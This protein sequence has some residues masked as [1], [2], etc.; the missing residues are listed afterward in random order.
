MKRPIFIISGFLLIG[1]LAIAGSF[2]WKNFRGALPLV[3]P[4][5][6]EVENF[7]NSTSSTG[8]GISYLK[9]A[10]GFSVSVF[11]KDLPGARVMVKDSF[12]NYW[13]SQTS[14]GVVS[15]LE[16]D[17]SRGKVVNQG[18]VF[19]NL[20]NPHGLAFDPEFYFRLFIA[21][22]DRIISVPT[23]S[24][25]DTKE[26]I[27]LP[28]GGGH[29][30][31]TIGF[32][33]DGRLYVS[34]G[35]SCNVC[36]E[37][38]ERRAKI[39]S[40]NK[41]GTDFKEFARGLRNTVFFAWH[42]NTGKMWGTDMGRDL[43]GDNI[44]PDEINIIEEGKNYGWPICYGKN[45][46]DNN[47]DKNVYFRNPCA[48]PFEEPSFVD[49]PAHSA[50]L[51][52]AFIP[53][54]SGWPKDYW[55]N[56]LVAYHGSWNR[57]EPTGYKVVRYKLNGSGNLLSGEAVDFISG[58]LLS[59]NKVLGRPAGVLVD[60]AGFVLISDDKAGIIYKVMATR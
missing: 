46:H 27:R 55:N 19:K 28:S 1:V 47:F 2:I 6:P 11:A 17:K 42:P 16:V 5:P 10:P 24:E 49:I 33:P 38:D 26:I 8:N 31:R 32:G 58:W 12:G 15:L 45:I 50:P 37:D 23:Y 20:N 59:D 21:E 56:L 35:S 30:T 52:L 3:L 7:I 29:F 53:P 51:G 25:P 40:L 60:P 4:D 9:T 57:S 13:V 34:I 36:R 18:A 14:Q 41:D 39:F 44:P 43:L 22:E 54:E 48:E